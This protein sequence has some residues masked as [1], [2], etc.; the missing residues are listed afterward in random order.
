MTVYNGLVSRRERWAVLIFYSTTDIIYI[1][2][3]MVFHNSKRISNNK[4]IS[5]QHGY[6]E[7]AK[8]SIDSIYTRFSTFQWRAKSNYI[9]GPFSP[10]FIPV[11]NVNDSRL[12]ASL[13][14]R[15]HLP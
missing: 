2:N 6:T 7:V 12:R 14:I 10:A 13:I 3:T 15:L 9:A 8:K 11:R 5:Q 4:G 1:A